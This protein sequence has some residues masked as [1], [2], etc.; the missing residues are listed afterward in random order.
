MHSS[1]SKYYQFFAWLIVPIV[2]GNMIDQFRLELLNAT[3]IIQLVLIFILQ[4][5]SSGL[6]YYLLA[7]VGN[8][9]VN[10]VRKQL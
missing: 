2:T 4:A 7:Y 10:Q 9:M 5:V 6:S 1:Y 8:R 3:M